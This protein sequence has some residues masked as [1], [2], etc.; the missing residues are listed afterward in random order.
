MSLEDARAA[1]RAAVK[2]NHPD[3]MIARGV[4]PEAAKL[5]ERRLIAI[6]EAWEEIRERLAA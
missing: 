5:A 6:N 4:P 3:A 2:E 1:W